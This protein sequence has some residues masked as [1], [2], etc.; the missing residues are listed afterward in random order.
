MISAEIS[1]SLLY[2]P[3]ESDS[4]EQNKYIY[5]KQYIKESPE[6]K[7]LG[8]E[9]CLLNGMI[10]GSKRVNFLHMTSVKTLETGFIFSRHWR[11]KHPKG[12]NWRRLVENFPNVDSFMFTTKYFYLS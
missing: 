8:W 1:R 4:P 12:T 2:G 5:M 3:G 11:K 10:T 6:R 7:T 9:T